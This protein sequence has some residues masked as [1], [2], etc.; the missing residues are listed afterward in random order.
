MLKKSSQLAFIFNMFMKI[1]VEITKT[2]KKE[3]LK[4]CI[5]MAYYSSYTDN[6]I[7]V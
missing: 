6:P 4:L 1:G 2:T 3:K 7:Y 5:G